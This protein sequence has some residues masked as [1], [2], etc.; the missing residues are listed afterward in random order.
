MPYGRTVTIWAVCD[1]CDKCIQESDLATGSTAMAA[2]LA[3]DYGWV[4]CGNGKTFCPDCRERRKNR[5][6]S[7]GANA[8]RPIP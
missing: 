3:R 1:D 4:V 2:M 5:E 7:A 8:A 6:V